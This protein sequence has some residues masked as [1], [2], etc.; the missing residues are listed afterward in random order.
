MPVLL[1]AESNDARWTSDSARFLRVVTTLSTVFA[2]C[3]VIAIFLIGFSALPPRPLEP[4]GLVEVPVLSATSVSPAAAPSQDHGVR[5]RLPDT[6]QVLRGAF[7]EDDSIIDQPPTAPARNP[8]S[9]PAHVS[10]P[11]ASASDGEFLKRG[12]TNQSR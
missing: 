5:V 12:C 2:L 9:A 10:H 1:R 11:E 7:A 4:K 8:D 6:N 3:G